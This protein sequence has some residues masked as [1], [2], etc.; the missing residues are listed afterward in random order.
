MVHVYPGPTSMTRYKNMVTNLFH[1]LRQKCST[2]TLLS[3]RDESQLKIH[4]LTEDTLELEEPSGS[5]TKILLKPASHIEDEPTPCLWTGQ[6]E[7]DPNSR[8]TVT[9]CIGHE[10]TAVTLA[11]SK[12]VQTFNALQC[13]IFILITIKVEGGVA[14]LWFTS[15]ATYQLGLLVSAESLSAAEDGLQGHSANVR[16]LCLYLCL[17]FWLKPSEDGQCCHC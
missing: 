5:K 12:V 3:P 2:L 16:Y 4:W 10:E 6:L 14:D 11:S 17:P 8:V 7:D 9:G 13:Y 1:P 15:S